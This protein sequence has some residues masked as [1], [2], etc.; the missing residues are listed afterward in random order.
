[1][2]LDYKGQEVKNKFQGSNYSLVGEK[3][4]C[5]EVE[6]TTP[7]AGL[8]ARPTR[9]WPGN[10]AEEGLTQPPTP[11][12]LKGQKTRWTAWDCNQNA[13][14]RVPGTAQDGKGRKVHGRVDWRSGA[15]L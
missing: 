5:S 9:R 8:E 4:M 13:G 6:V 12:K 15:H 3:R 10:R 14:H 7:W 1:M 11:R 2:W